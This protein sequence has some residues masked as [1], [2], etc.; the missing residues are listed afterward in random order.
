M[1]TRLA[2]RAAQCVRLDLKSL[3]VVHYTRRV[4]EV[5]DLSS[6][7]LVKLMRYREEIRD[8][9]RGRRLKDAGISGNDSPGR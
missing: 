7:D 3:Y 9:E 5:G 2:P 1:A 8:G 6:S 4:R